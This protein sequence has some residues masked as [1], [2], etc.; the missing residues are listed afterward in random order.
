[1]NCFFENRASRICQ[2]L[3]IYLLYKCPKLCWILANVQ[4]VLWLLFLQILFQKI[5]GLLTF[6][7][8]LLKCSGSTAFCEEKFDTRSYVLIL[9]SH[10]IKSVLIIAIIVVMLRI[11]FKNP[12]FST[13][14]PLWEHTCS[15]NREGQGWILSNSFLTCLVC[16]SLLFVFVLTF[17]R[18]VAWLH[19]HNVP[20]VKELR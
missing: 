12:K 10:N 1:M 14:R 17:E 20:Y 16:C 3:W 2:F 5:S 7:W 6:I 8:P 4:A 13:F 19:N 15:W 9:N 11:F 18:K